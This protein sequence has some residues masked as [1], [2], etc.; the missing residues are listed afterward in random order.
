MNQ[1]KGL[2]VIALALFSLVG[3]A[4]GNLDGE[5]YWESIS[6][7][8]RLAERYQR[9]KQYS[10]A[11][12][13]YLHHIQARLS[14]KDKP[15]WENP[16]FY[17]LLI[18]DL[19][20]SEADIPEALKSYDMARKNGVDIGLVSDRYRLVA[21][22]LAKN[23]DFDGAIEILNTYHDYDPLLFDMMRDRL[24]REK[25]ESEEAQMHGAQ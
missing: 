10:L 16:H 1:T 15:E 24:A 7:H 4:T 23:G 14:V 2:F 25:V 18:G 12:T 6:E 21:N 22:S 8:L 9:K 17:Y 13:S 20:L 11:R 5:P 3:C 19:F